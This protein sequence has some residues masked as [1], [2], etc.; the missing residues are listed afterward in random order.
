MSNITL[1]DLEEQVFPL[2]EEDIYNIILEAENNFNMALQEFKKKKREL[3]AI[4]IGPFCSWQ[5]TEKE[6]WFEEVA[7]MESITSER[8]NYIQILVAEMAQIPI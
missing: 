7:K 3:L 5:D 2:N 4:N 8:N 6:K 1:F